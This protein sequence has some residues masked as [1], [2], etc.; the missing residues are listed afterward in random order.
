MNKLFLFGAV[1]LLQGCLFWI[2]QDIDCDIEIFL[3]NNRPDLCSEVGFISYDNSPFFGCW[4]FRLYKDA[5]RDFTPNLFVYPTELR[6]EERQF[7]WIRDCSDIVHYPLADEAQSFSSVDLSA[8][9]NSTR[10]CM[11]LLYV[12][13]KDDEGHFHWG[14]RGEK[15]FS[16]FKLSQ[17]SNMLYLFDLEE[18]NQQI[19]HTLQA[20]LL[21]NRF[22]HIKELKEER[23]MIESY[24]FVTSNVVIPYTSIEQTV[25]GVIYKFV[26]EKK[27]V[28]G[29]LTVRFPIYY[30]LM[31]DWSF[32]WDTEKIAMKK[33]IELYCDKK[34]S[35]RYKGIVT[36]YVNKL[37]RFDD[38]ER[39]CKV[40]ELQHCGK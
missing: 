39:S 5:L 11:D 21:R 16:S 24:R 27:R 12:C 14:R 28:V 15:D 3:D 31:E 23:E 17:R 13:Y 2:P 6:K 37:F 35:G 36:T 18:E 7:N 40:V 29:S 25:T 19:E 4:G 33:F 26:D 32:M 22:P 38:F 20:W 10:R 30:G 8:F 1:F 9:T 34:C